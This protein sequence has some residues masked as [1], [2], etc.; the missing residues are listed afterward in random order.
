MKLFGMC[1]CGHIEE[2]HDQHSCVGENC[3]CAGFEPSEEEE[4][5]GEGQEWLTPVSS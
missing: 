4:E 3:R 1:I 5:E 2:E